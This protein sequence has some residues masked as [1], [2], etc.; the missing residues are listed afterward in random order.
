[1]PTILRRMEIVPIEWTLWFITYSIFLCS[2]L[3]DTSTIITWTH[4]HTTWLQRIH[5]WWV[6][7]IMEKKLFGAK[8]ILV[9]L[10]FF[11]WLYKPYIRARVCLRKYTNMLYNYLHGFSALMQ[12]W[13][14]KSWRGL[15]SRKLIFRFPCWV[16]PQL[17]ATS[18]CVSWLPCSKSHCISHTKYSRLL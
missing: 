3:I 15:V 8:V 17:G 1:M 9:S 7:C 10:L 16:L 6:Y 14:G 13:R 4:S 18:D 11:H 12:L 2:F 5:Q